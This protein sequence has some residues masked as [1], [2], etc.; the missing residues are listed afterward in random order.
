MIEKRIQLHGNE[1]MK[2]ILKK[3]YMV[4]SLIMILFENL[5]KEDGPMFSPVGIPKLSK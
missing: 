4:H 1:L 5:M 3:L 2:Q